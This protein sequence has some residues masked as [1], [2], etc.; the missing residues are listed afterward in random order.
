MDEI[1]LGKALGEEKRGK[2]QRKQEKGNKKRF[3]SFIGSKCCAE[4]CF[5]V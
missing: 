4:N 5:A 1:C 3:E 2:L